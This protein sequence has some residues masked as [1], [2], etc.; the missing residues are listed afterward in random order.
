MQIEW[1]IIIL[2]DLFFWCVYI[3]NNNI[4]IGFWT[5][6]VDYF[7][8]LTFW[9]AKG[10][11]FLF[12]PYWVQ[13]LLEDLIPF[14]KALFV[15]DISIWTPTFLKATELHISWSKSKATVNILNDYNEYKGMRN[16]YNQPTNSTE[17]PYHYKVFI[18]NSCALLVKSTFLE[19]HLY[20]F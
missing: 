18:F 3:I 1:V 16:D 10:S 7:P 17:S 9:S 6:A 13:C 11:L 2:R 15:D 12:W 8:D 4:A 19:C 14:V 20:T 5:Q